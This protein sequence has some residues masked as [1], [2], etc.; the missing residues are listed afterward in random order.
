M[1]GRMIESIKR[2]YFKYERHL[3]SLG[4]IAGFVFDAVSLERVDQFWE[5]LWIGIHLIPAAICIIAIN[6][7]ESKGTRPENAAP[8][9]RREWLHFWLVFIL[10]FAFGGLLSAFLV[11]YFRSS[12]L[13]TSWPFLLLLAITFALNEILKKHYS[14]LI[15][16]LSVFFISLY[17]YAIY[18]VPILT[19]RIGTGIFL[20]SGFISLVVLGGFLFLLRYVARERFKNS[21]RLLGITIASIFIIINVLYFTNLIP[22]IPL[23]LQDGG[24][25]HLLT[26]TSNGEYSFVGEQKTWRDYIFNPIVHHIS[27]QPI[28]VYS[29]VFSPT[30]LNTKIIH[31]WQHY[32]E[33]QK[34]WISVTKVPLTIIGGRGGGYRTYS[35][36]TNLEDGKWR[37]DVETEKGA[38]IGRISFTIVTID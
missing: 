2:I 31:N 17:C 12:T 23:S 3:S 14:R 7:L 26:R 36:K 11:F 5:N 16:Q 22:P 29:A 37:V 1:A 27:G 30:N 35:V 34:K 6:I 13:A 8:T 10:Q 9:N 28:Y 15:F 21:K 19:H 38:D 4:L 33:K 32:D 20:L 24:V 25:Y 18:M